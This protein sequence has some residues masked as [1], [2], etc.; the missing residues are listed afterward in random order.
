MVR[1]AKA[2]LPKSARSR[3]RQ[4]PRF[5]QASRY[6]TAIIERRNREMCWNAHFQARCTWQSVEFVTARSVA[7]FVVVFER[8]HLARP[9]LVQIPFANQSGG[10]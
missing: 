9:N 2:L 1:P 4:Q 10:A 5:A 7:K 8:N 3:E 6:S